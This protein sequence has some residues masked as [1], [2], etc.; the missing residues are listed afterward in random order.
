MTLDT[1]PDLG[2]FTLFLCSRLS[3][4][5][6]R[7]Q[8]KTACGYRHTPLYTPGPLNRGFTGK[9]VSEVHSQEQVSEVHCNSQKVMHILGTSSRSTTWVR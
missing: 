1:I 3:T 9:Q 5:Q 2:H 8:R 7:S 6:K 4:S